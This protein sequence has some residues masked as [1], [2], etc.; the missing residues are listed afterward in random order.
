[1]LLLHEVKFE[2]RSK[3]VVVVGGNV[4]IT[5]ADD[6]WPEEWHGDV[7]HM[8]LPNINEKVEI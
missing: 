1:M 6:D 3:P 2:K 4:D 8:W 5:A 7:I